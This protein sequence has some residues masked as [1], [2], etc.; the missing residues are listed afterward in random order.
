MNNKDKKKKENAPKEETQRDKESKTIEEL[1]DMSYK[2]GYVKNN[3]TIHLQDFLFFLSQAI[4]EE[5]ESTANQEY[6]NFK[7]EYDQEKEA[8]KRYYNYKISNH[9]PFEDYLK[10]EETATSDK[11]K[12][13][14]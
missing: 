14:S 7:K 9:N 11:K 10:L 2:I 3:P 13:Q 4:E 1:I 6:I 12:E 8:K 5:L